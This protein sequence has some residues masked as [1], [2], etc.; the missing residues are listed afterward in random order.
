MHDLKE[1]ARQL[2][3]AKSRVTMAKYAE[4]LAR[5]VYSAALRVKQI[6]TLERRGITPGAKVVVTT[7]DRW[8]DKQ[9]QVMGFLGCD[10]SEG[11]PEQAAILSRLKK[12]GQT[13]CTAV[14]IYCVASIEPY[15]GSPE[16]AADMERKP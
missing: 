6:K 11:T 7:A 2:E 13:S 9:R 1:L 14:K 10:G 16:Q 15:E 5:E 12:N 4:K 8:P 3:A